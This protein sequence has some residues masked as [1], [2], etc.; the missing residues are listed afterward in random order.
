MRTLFV[1]VC[2]GLSLSA[3]AVPEFVATVRSRL[4]AERRQAPSLHDSVTSKRHGLTH[5]YNASLSERSWQVKALH[6]EQR[7]ANNSLGVGIGMAVKHQRHMVDHQQVHQVQ[8]KGEYLCVL[9]GNTKH[10]HQVPKVTQPNL[11]QAADRLY[12]FGFVLPVDSLM[13]RHWLRHY[14]SLGVRPN[15]TS[16]AIRV[17]EGTNHQPALDA[18][19]HVLDSM[20]VPR[21]N[22]EILRAAPSD[23][24]K[25][26][27]INKAMDAAP[28]DSFFIYADVDELFDYPC[29]I[30]PHNLAKYKCMTG[31]MVDQMAS[32]GNISDALE[33]PS[34]V[35]QFPMQC[36]V[37]FYL[38]PRSIFY[39]TIIVT[40]GGSKFPK[41]RFRTTHAVNSSCTP[42]G[43]VRH[44][45]MTG[46]QLS[47]NAERRNIDPQKPDV[48]KVAVNYAN[49]TCGTFDPKT[50]ACMDYTKLYNFMLK[51]VEQVAR[52]GVSVPA[53][54]LCQRN[55][56]FDSRNHTPYDD[57]MN[58]TLERIKEHRAAVILAKL[59]AKAKSQ[60]AKVK[61]SSTRSRVPSDSQ[62][63]L[64]LQSGLRAAFSVALESG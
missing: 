50:G 6:R 34:L 35:D 14:H 7:R 1:T 43:L 20:G 30:S 52:T 44:Y 18:T 47:N 58:Q 41:R 13:L 42:T 63:R 59:A 10:P 28:I 37:R 9:H 24:L 17:D 39:K 4:S 27:S 38:Q 48:N 22:I 40:T 55:L 33:S 5:G 56:S 49:T 15:Q 12:L 31:L 23:D 19:L 60:A 25:I 2:F 57:M 26:A 45:S 62:D 51:Q 61:T 53:Q 54:Q 29:N 8:K 16:M 11:A 46:Q 3:N 64:P 32:N 21:E 36:K